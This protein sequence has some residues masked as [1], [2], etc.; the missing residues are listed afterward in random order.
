V[1]QLR[2]QNTVDRTYFE[3]L[4]RVDT[5]A[6]CVDDHDSHKG[7]ARDNFNAHSWCDIN[8]RGS[9]DNGVCVVT[10]P[11][12]RIDGDVLDAVVVERHPEAAHRIARRMPHLYAKTRGKCSGAEAIQ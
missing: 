11:R 5:I 12:L 7:N 1:K 9:Y 3:L 4:F 8:Y 10:R 2:P 6:G